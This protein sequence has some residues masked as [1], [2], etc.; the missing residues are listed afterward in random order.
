MEIE[1]CDL[2]ATGQEEE[3][4]P[5]LLT[6]NLTWDQLVVEALHVIRCREFSEYNPKTGL[7][8]PTRFC[9]YNMAFFDLDKESKVVPR[10]PISMV[11]ASNFWRFEHSVNVISIKVAESDVGYPINVYG[12]VLARD[13]YDYR[14]IHLFKRRRDNPQLI[15]SKKDML[16]LRG[17]FRALRVTD[18]MFFEVHLKIK[19]DDAADQHFSKAL[20][21]HS[22]SHYTRQP[23]AVQ[24]KSCLS[25]VVMVYS[26]VPFAVEASLEVQILK[27]ASHFNGKVIAWT[28][29]NKNKI[30]LYDSKM[31][32]TQTELGIGGFVT[33]TRPIVAVPLDEGLVLKVSHKAECF[34]LVLRHDVGRDVEQCTH[35]L[36][37]YE[38]R[39][40]VVW[41]AV[42]RQ[43]RPKMWEHIGHLDVLW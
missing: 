22:A 3:D 7:T 24:L 11:P 35:R 9:Q 31:A 37:S 5:Q 27:G 40:K 38:L 12:T 25:T 33:L 6:P 28:T 29:E 42:D 19:S 23:M 14:C 20:L 26:P 43:R 36:G 34:E 2:A 8:V 1:H 15:R 32:G 41:T 13:Q 18:N 30:T 16:T 17:P 39:V 4:A 10:L 21:E